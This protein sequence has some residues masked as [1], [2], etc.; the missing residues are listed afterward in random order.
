[1][2]VLNS[3]AH[4][5]ELRRHH[6]EEPVMG[7]TL[8]LEVFS[9]AEEQAVSAARD[10]VRRIKALER[11][12][13]DYDPDSESERLALAGPG[14]HA[15]SPEL[16]GMLA[17]AT[18]LS[19]RSD[20][21]F[22]VG[23]GALTRLWRQARRSGMAPDA[24]ALLAAASSSGWRKIRMDSKSMRAGL[25]D[26]AMRLDFGGIA[27]GHA[28][29]EAARVL[30]LAGL[31]VHLVALDGDIALG[32]PPPGERGWTVSMD[33]A[34]GRTEVATLELAHCALST[35]G[36]A[37][38]HFDSGG[39]RLSHILDPRTGRPITRAVAVTVLAQDG[40]IADSAA[41]A[42]CVAAPTE[43]SRIARR[44]GVAARLVELDG[45]APRVL[46]IGTWPISAVE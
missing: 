22:D 25:T 29:T 28:V 44:F 1:M 32:A 17:A 45:A 26:R 11:V 16:L 18:A 30:Q 4:G 31:G 15:A 13:S 14:L 8:R 37:F 42:L 5:Q 23:C 46:T 3:A 12:L 6:F 35:S 19:V 43:R 34:P 10:A 20:G 2:I 27:K 9:P 33:P 24:N 7:C 40:L 36:D 39:A 38:Q 41:T 21:A